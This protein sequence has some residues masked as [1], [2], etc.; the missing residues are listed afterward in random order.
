MFA[1]II[2]VVFWLTVIMVSLVAI[3]G[4]RR[5]IQDKGDDE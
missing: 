5:V 3:E 4:I 1:N 2:E